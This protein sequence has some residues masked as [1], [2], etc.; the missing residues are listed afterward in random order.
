VAD[1]PVGQLIHIGDL[2][3]VAA[4]TSHCWESVWIIGP[5]PELCAERWRNSFFGTTRDSEVLMSP[6]VRYHPI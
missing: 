1:Q 2:V 4:Y 6:K 5:V 3:K